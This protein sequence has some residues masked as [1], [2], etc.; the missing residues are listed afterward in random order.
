MVVYYVMWL[1]RWSVEVQSVVLPSYL[2]WEAQWTEPRHTGHLKPH[3][4]MNHHINL[5]F[6]RNSDGS[7]SSLKMADYCRNM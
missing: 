7:R 2:S 6:S 4:M 5:Y 3:Y 1:S